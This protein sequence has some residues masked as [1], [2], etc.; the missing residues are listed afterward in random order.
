M[1]TKLQGFTL[2]L[3]LISLS[4]D[5]GVASNRY[6]SHIVF[7]PLRG[8]VTQFG[9]CQHWSDCHRINWNITTTAQN[10]RRTQTKHRK[11]KK[12]H[13][14][15]KLE[16]IQMEF[17]FFCKFISVYIMSFTQLEN[18]FN[19]YVIVILQ[20]LFLPIWCLELII[21]KIKQHYLK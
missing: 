13:R 20:T 8:Q 1:M 14:W 19:Y 3:Q 21:D 12:G 9:Q 10:Y 15:T 17:C 16:R 18:H 2:L 5:W 11:T 4:S 7:S 6:Y